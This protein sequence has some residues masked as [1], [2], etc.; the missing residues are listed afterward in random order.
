MLVQQNQTQGST[1]VT[2]ESVIDSIFV[3][4]TNAVGDANDNANVNDP[5]IRIPKVRE[6]GR[7]TEDF[8]ECYVP[9][10]VSIGPYYFGDPRFQLFE[11]RKPVFAMSLLSGNKE[12]LRR[13]YNKLFEMVQE[14]RSFYAKDSTTEFCDNVFTKMM[15]LDGC[16]ILQ[17]IILHGDFQ[18]WIKPDFQHEWIKLEEIDL[19][20]Y[21]D[22]LLLENQIPFKVLTEVMKLL[23]KE[24][25]LEKMIQRYLKNAICVSPQKPKLQKWLTSILCLRFDQS[26][27]VERPKLQEMH[28]KPDHLLHLLHIL[29]TGKVKH[30]KICMLIDHRCN[31]RNVSELVDLGI[32][33]KPSDTRSFAY[34][35][36][37]KG[38]WGFSPIVKLPPI[39]VTDGTRARLL[40]L[41]AYE[42]CS[43]D[44]DRWVSS[45][46]SLLDSLIDDTADV[47]LLRKAWV[48]QTYM[49]SDEEVSKLFN[50][51]G[52]E[53]FMNFG[54]TVV[55]QEIQSHYGSLRNRLLSQL[56]HEYF[57]SPWAI[58]ALLGA[59]M[60]LL[61]TGVQ[62]YYTI[63]SPQGTCD[64]LCM[65][66]K[67][68]H[69][70]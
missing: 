36:F 54:Y 9:K 44:K 45:Y 49:G 33:F 56:K 18:K 39:D 37:S 25:H 61:L 38:W 47:K 68:N 35:V 32:H 5:L 2:I 34:F 57:R 48:L 55:M 21:R 16:F 70:L 23:N 13:L 40:N 24:N 51:I 69:H 42:N 4:G 17:C 62:T 28:T 29:H 65:F 3:P 6:M 67:R 60:A 15:L 10:I 46:I 22:F 64:D 31:F 53:L 8:K 66:L 41:A 26:L 59:L 63:W 7:D 20:H 12:A 58:F 27:H 30:S 11:Q 1:G 43:R 19:I 52:K 14:L 50:G